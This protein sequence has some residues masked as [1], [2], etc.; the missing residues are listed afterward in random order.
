MRRVIDSHTQPGGG[1]DEQW[2]STRT[3]N[4]PDEAQMA[5]ISP[6][7]GGYTLAYYCTPIFRSII[8]LHCLYIM[9]VRIKVAGERVLGGRDLNSDDKSSPREPWGKSGGGE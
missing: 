3:N 5:I 9:S 6:S 2:E 4:T 7:F 1:G 8:K